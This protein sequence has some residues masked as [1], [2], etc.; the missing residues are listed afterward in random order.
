MSAS[1]VFGT[2]VLKSSTNDAAEKAVDSVP[3]T[4]PADSVS[5]VQTRY[6]SGVRKS[7]RDFGSGLFSAIAFSLSLVVSRIVNILD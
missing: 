2:S 6:S 1:P 3:S 5:L 4:E 7:A